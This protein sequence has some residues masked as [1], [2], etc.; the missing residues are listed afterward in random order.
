ME[1]CGATR[2]GQMTG[3]GEEDHETRRRRD[4]AEFLKA[5]RAA[6]KPGD[7]GLPHIG[8]RRTPGLRREELAQI[9]GIGTTWYTWL[10]Q[11][12]P[13]RVSPDFLQRLTRVLRLSPHDAAYLA[14]L[15]GQPTTPLPRET[16]MIDGLQR[17]L[18]GYML[19]PA[20]ASDPTGNVLAYNQIGDFVYRFSDNPGPRRDNMFWRLFMD[21]YRRHLYVDWED[22]ARYAVGLMRG[23]YASRKD[24]LAFQE[25]I[26][27]LRRSS[28]EFRTM[29]EE[30]SRQGASSYAPDRL[31]LR[32]P[33][34]GRLNFLLV[35]LLLLSEDWVIFL[36]PLDEKTT[37]AMTDLAPLKRE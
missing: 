26:E 29:W 34:L 24:D 36:S 2:T 3:R 19:G 1:G 5:R 11:A 22:F 35:L 13:I 21:P 8:R 37:R 17:V 7:F 14:S 20:T 18:D 30:S 12:R 10:E 28:P 6:L 27:E 32:V 23:L 4:L 33:G 15:A 31:H 9:A 16:G 25:M